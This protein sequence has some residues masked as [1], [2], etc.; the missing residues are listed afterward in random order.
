LPKAQ[1]FNRPPDGY[2]GGNTAEGTDALLILTS[3][4]WNTPLGFQAL[5]RDTIGNNNTATGLRALFS[6]IP[7]GAATPPTVFR[8]YSATMQ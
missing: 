3:G 7:A 1:A 4:V 6:T 2:P 5:N 8:H